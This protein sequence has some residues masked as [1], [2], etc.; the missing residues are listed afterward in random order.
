MNPDK[1]QYLRVGTGKVDC[2]QKRLRRDNQR[3]RR[4]GREFEQRINEKRE[5]QHEISILPNVSERSKKEVYP[6][7]L[8][9]TLLSG[10]DKSTSG[11]E[12]VGAE[13]RL[14]R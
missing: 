13:A 8:L 7:D 6:L 5:F 2:L 4:T 12:A 1:H 14:Q 3:S 9:V 11:R 10:L